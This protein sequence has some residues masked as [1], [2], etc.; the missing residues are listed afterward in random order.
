MTRMKAILTLAA[1]I[2]TATYGLADQQKVDKLWPSIIFYG[3]GTNQTESERLYV[4]G[5][6]GTSAK[7]P[8]QVNNGSGTGTGSPVQPAGSKRPQIF[9]PP[10]YRTGRQ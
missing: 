4:E 3:N 6:G 2:L 10:S 7:Q 5:D 9:V 1:L 8:I